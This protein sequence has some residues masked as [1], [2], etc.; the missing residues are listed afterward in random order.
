[1]DKHLP[2]HDAEAHGPNSSHQ[3]VVIS[4]FKLEHD[5]STSFTSLTFRDQSGS[6]EKTE[7]TLV[8]AAVRIEY[9]QQVKHASEV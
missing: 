6:R 1:M 7:T 4:V 2:T 8:I 5:P 9:R 3:R